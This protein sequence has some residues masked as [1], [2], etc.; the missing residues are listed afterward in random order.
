MNNT[1]LYSMKYLPKNKRKKNDYFVN[2]LIF[3]KYYNIV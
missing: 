3:V 1:N 2:E